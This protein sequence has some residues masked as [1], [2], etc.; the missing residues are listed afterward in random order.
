MQVGARATRTLERSINR[1]Y[2]PTTDQFLSIDPL[3]DETGQPYVFTNDNPLNET[4]PLGL[5]G[6]YCIDGQSHYYQGDKYGKTG[7][8]K[9]PTS[10][11]RTA[12]KAHH[13]KKAVSYDQ[14]C[15]SA[16]FVQFCLSVT[17]NLSFYG[18]AGVGAGLSVGPSITINNSTPQSG[19]PLSGSSTCVDVSAGAG[20]T[21]CYENDQAGSSSGVEIGVGGGVYVSDSHKLFGL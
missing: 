16:I 21:H 19:D 20:P 5:K 18:S 15:I 3:V 1:Y 13:K 14:A 10:G 2:D 7:S 17:S 8:G 9:C 6:W 4:D 11:P 12:V